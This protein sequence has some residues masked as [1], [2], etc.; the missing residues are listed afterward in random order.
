[1]EQ[2]N[3]KITKDG[4]DLETRD[5]CANSLS[6]LGLWNKTFFS[7]SVCTLSPEVLNHSSWCGPCLGWSNSAPPS[8]NL[9]YGSS[10]PIYKQPCEFQSMYHTSNSLQR[11]WVM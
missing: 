9:F 7:P 2:N 3:N 1:M 5:K 11:V 10:R 4:R 8:L 6:G